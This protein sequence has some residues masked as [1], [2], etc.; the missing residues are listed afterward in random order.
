MVTASSAIGWFPTPLIAAEITTMS[1]TG[2]TM[3]DNAYSLASG[4]DCNTIRY[5]E[6]NYYCREQLPSNQVVDTRLYCYRTLADITCYDQPQPYQRN[7]QVAPS[8]I[9]V[10]ARTQRLEN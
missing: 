7:Q 5:L 6:G 3:V 4:K 9:K 1:L 2:K 10:G 8:L